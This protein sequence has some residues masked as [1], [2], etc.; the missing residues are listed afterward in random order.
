MID[1]RNFT[2]LAVIFTPRPRLLEAWHVKIAKTD[3]GRPHGDSTEED[4]SLRNIV[5]RRKL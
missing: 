4:A 5:L 2:S 1:E 3:Q